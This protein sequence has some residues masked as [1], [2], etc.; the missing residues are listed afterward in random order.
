MTAITP[1]RIS[2]PDT[3]W[4]EF[5]GTDQIDIPLTGLHQLR[6]RERGVPFEML[7]KA[8]PSSDC[9]IVFGQSAL[10]TRE[11]L[12]LPVYHRWTWFDDFPQAACL[13]LNDPTL[14]LSETLFGGWFQGTREHFYMEDGARIVAR[15]AQQ[16]GIPTSRIFFYGSSAGG[17]SSLMMAAELGNA[18]AIA[19]IPQ[20]DMAKYHVLSAVDA[21]RT[22]C[23]G[24]MTL[25]AI[26]AEYGDRLSVLHRFAKLGKVPNI[27]YLQNVADTLHLE[28]HVFPFIAGIEPLFKDSISCLNRR[29][30]L[31]LYCGRTDKGDGHVA[32]SRKEAVR[33]IKMAM[34][35]FT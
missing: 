3:E 27:L 31:E 33:A 10:S 25:D 12:A 26:S 6:V 32:A 19:E 35:I 13:T 30:L 15:I 16:L 22:H 11:N 23:Y 5:A 29:I 21:L 4:L 34:R 18:T 1:S 14:Y 20:T 8:N 9:L 24:G 28:R 7:Y 2:P 17:F